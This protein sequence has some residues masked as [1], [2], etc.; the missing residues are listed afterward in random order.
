MK[1]EIEGMTS[2]DY[3]YLYSAYADDTT[4]CLKDIISAKH[5]VDTFI[6]FFVIFR[7]KTKSN[8]IRNCGYWSTESGSSSSLWCALHRSE[9]AYVKNIR[10]PFILQLKIERI[11]KIL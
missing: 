10:Y 7:I 4:F 2:F 3:S 1:S 9:Y 8:E 11:E 6:F 5:R